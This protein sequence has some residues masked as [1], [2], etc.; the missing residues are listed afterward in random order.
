MRPLSTTLLRTG[1][2]VLAAAFAL[3]AGTSPIS[4]HEYTPVSTWTVNNCQT[5]Y[6]AERNAAARYHA[7]AQKADQEGYS[8][9]ASLFRTAAAVEEVHARNQEVLIRKL[10]GTPAPESKVPQV[11]TTR[12]NLRFSAEWAQREERNMYAVLLEQARRQSY[13]QIIRVDGDAQK[14]AG[15]LA[16]MFSAELQ[17]LDEHKDDSPR[18]YYVCQVDGHVLMH[19]HSEVCKTC[20]HP[21]KKFRVVS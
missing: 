5:A 7:Y 2:A 21:R 9:I 13:Q 18:S 11:Q 15:D 10:G 16:E 6:V 12:E 20:F 14:S 8:G 17:S 3:S 19:L 1:Q 4:A